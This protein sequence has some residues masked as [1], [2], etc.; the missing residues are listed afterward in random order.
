MIRLAISVEGQTEETFIKTVLADA[1]RQKRIFLVPILLGRAR[2]RNRGGGNVTVKELVREMLE[3]HRNF[4]AVT[5][6]VDFYGFRGRL[7]EESVEDLEQRLYREFG[8]AAQHPNQIIPY[9]QKYEF[10]NL[11]FSDVEAFRVAGASNEIIQKLHA[12]RN[13]FES[14][15]DINDSHH[16]APSRRI[17]SVIPTYRKVL[18]GPMVAAQVGLNIL[19]QE[20]PR[21]DR[22]LTRLEL[23]DTK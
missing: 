7:P 8:N 3:L 19:R 16:S 4:D 1:L 22:W 13:D 23:L 17:K 9:V 10:E 15:E 14:P 21:F 20:C 11:L 18:S 2:N 12:I 6:L 5:C